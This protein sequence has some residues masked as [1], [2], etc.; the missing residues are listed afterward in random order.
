ME[1]Y[2]PDEVIVPKKR[3]YDEMSLGNLMNS[4]NE[5]ESKKSKIDINNLLQV[6][7]AATT[8]PNQQQNNN[9]ASAAS[10][11][12]EQTL[13][14]NTHQYNDSVDLLNSTSDDHTEEYLQ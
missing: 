7:N 13:F 9:I 6:I 12:L 8:N 5:P 14:D 3:S 1:E 4:T 11:F 10:Q 2:N